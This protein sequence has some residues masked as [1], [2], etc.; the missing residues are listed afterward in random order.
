MPSSTISNITNKVSYPVLSGMQDNNERLKTSIRKLI[1]IVMYISFVLMFGLAAI[2]KPLF[3]VLLGPKWLPSVIIFQVL[4]LAYAITPMHI[5]NQNIMKVKGRSD[6]FLKTEI[7]KYLLF[8]PLLVAGVVFGLEVLIGGIVVFYW[9]GF[10]INAI[11]SKKLIGYSLGEQTLHFL[12]VMAVAVFPALA[13]L[14]SGYLIDI[15]IFI[16]LPL[17]L[18]IYTGLV[19][20]ISV[21]FRI[22]AFFE[23]VGI[24]RERLTMAN[25]LNTISKQ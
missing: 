15:N 8:T 3:L 5:I 22:E 12:P 1:S 21:I 10:I 14:A 6:L 25:L 11:Y 13:T 4:C 23:L 16:L 20:A 2:A 19:L 9:I 7:V 24:L 17:L 18:A